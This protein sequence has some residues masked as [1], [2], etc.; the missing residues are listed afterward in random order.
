[1]YTLPILISDKLTAETMKLRK[2]NPDTLPRPKHD[3][4][5]HNFSPMNY[6]KP[7]TPGIFG[8]PEHKNRD[9]DLNCKTLHQKF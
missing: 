3:R 8:P 5:Y 9:F 7:S 4:I 6:F 2:T 1:M